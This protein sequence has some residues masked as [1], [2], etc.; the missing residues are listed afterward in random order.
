MH[1]SLQRAQRGQALPLGIFLLLMAGAAI[2]F[3]FNS[4]QVT[5]EKMRVVNTADAVAYSAGIFQARALNYDAYVNRAIIANEIAIGQAVSLASWDRYV[6]PIESELEPYTSIPYVGWVVSYIQGYVSYVAGIVSY[7]ED[8][9]LA[10]FAVEVHGYAMQAL[11][12]SQQ[13]M[14]GP[15]DSALIANRLAVMR[16]VAQENDPDVTVDPVPIADDF[17]GLTQRYESEDERQRMAD[18]VR[19]SMDSF[20]TDRRWDFGDVFLCTG[21]LFKRRGGAQFLGVDGWKAMDT[22]S[23]HFYAPGKTP[24]SRCKHDEDPI[25]YGS[26]ESESGI[27]DSGASYGGSRHDNPNASSYA[28]SNSS[29]QLPASVSAEIPGFYDLAAEWITGSRATQEPRATLAIRV[30]KEQ[31]TQRYSGGSAS[32][33]PAGSLDL[34]PGEHQAGVTAAV[35]RV[36]VFFDR[37]DGNNPHHGKPER[38]S[39]FNPYWHARLTRRGADGKDAAK[40]DRDAGALRQGTVLPF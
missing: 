13:T 20:T 7:L 21:I 19:A 10:A 17:T 6:Q 23:L 9:D 37:P 12:L 30:Y 16:R 28:E 35:S 5:T 40:A 33:R 25:G 27:S 11:S 24:F 18:V 15:S 34:F 32:V 39:L 31:G 1:P 29:S 8:A 4:G 22:L 26:A 14:H 2:Y 36:E 3:L 38:A